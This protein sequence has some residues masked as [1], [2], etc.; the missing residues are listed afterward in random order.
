MKGKVLAGLGAF[1][2]ALV[3]VKVTKKIRQHK[4]SNEELAKRLGETFHR[5]SDFIR[6]HQ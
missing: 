5:E 6:S 3:A 4:E 2:V 1:V